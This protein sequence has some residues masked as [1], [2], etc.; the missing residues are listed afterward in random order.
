MSLHLVTLHGVTTFPSHTDG[1][2]PAEMEAVKSYLVPETSTLIK[3]W[4]CVRL[5][6]VGAPHQVI[7]GDTVKTS[8]IST[9]DQA[10]APERLGSTLIAAPLTIG[11]ML[12]LRVTYTFCPLV[13]EVYTCDYSGVVRVSRG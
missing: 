1:L 9:I 2:T 10:P 11:E 13:M 8:T 12:E 5:Q 4:G 3:V 6:I 7:A